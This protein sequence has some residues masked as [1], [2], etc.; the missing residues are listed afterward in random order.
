MNRLFSTDNG[1]EF[2]HV[3]AIKQSL[4]GKQESILFFCEPYHSSEKPRVEKNHTLTRHIWQDYLEQAEDIQHSLVG[5]ETYALRSRTI[6][7]L[8]ADAKEKHAMRYT[9]YRGLATVTAWVKL[10]FAT[11]NLKKLT[12]HK[13]MR[14]LFSGL[15]HILE[16]TSHCCEVASLTNCGFRQIWRKSQFVLLHTFFV[17]S[18]LIV[19]YNF[20]QGI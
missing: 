13:W 6:E 9:P 20:I 10:K 15:L 2:N 5:K 1:P 16:A 8:F 14:L 4:D 12:I 18:I 17:D 19:W 3:S 7:R 11:F